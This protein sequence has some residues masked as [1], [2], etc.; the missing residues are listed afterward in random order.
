MIRSPHARALEQND[1]RVVV[2]PGAEATM[3]AESR[4][5][6]VAAHRLPACKAVLPIGGHAQLGWWGRPLVAAAGLLVPPRL[7]H[8]CTVTSPYV[9]LFVDS[10]LL[11]SHPEPIRLDAGAVRRLLAALGSTDADGPDTCVDLAAGYTELRALAGRPARLDPRV[12]HAVQL[13]GTW[14]GRDPSSPASLTS[15]AHEVG[16]SAPRLRAL[17]RQD[18]GITLAHLRRWGR[19]RTAIADLPDSTA[20]LAAATAGFADQAHLARTAR[21]FIG[22]SPASLH[23]AER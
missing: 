18:V 15:L 8:S 17:V 16:L 11:P 1:R 7:A 3:F 4:P 5:F 23:R 20:A 22:R 2:A 10:W 9:A 6:R 14:S 21:E 13:C 19:L 12:A